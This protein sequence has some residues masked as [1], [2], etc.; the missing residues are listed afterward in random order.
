MREENHQLSIESVA[1]K[2]F[3]PHLELENIESRLGL[4]N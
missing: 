2:R 4:L 1:M 3:K